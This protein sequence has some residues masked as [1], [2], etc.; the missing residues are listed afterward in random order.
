MDSIGCYARH[1]LT[2][3]LVPTNSPARKVMISYL[4]DIINVMKAF[5]QAHRLVL[6]L[7]ASSLMSILLYGIG[8]I[9][10]GAS[11]F[12]F[13]NWNLLLAWLPLLFAG[14]LVKY[15]RANPWV[16]W[17]GAVL[18]LFWLGFLPNSFYLIS[19]I[20]HLTYPDSNIL[21]YV[22]LLFL[23]SWNGLILGFLSL[24]MLHKE[25]LKRLRR[26]TAHSWVAVVILLCSFAIYL[27][28]YLR[29]STWDIVINPAGILFDVSDRLI[30]PVAYGQTFQITGLF[31]MLLGTLYFTVWEVANSRP[32]DKSY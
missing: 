7:F 11:P 20:M 2:C 23:F 29:W 6:A 12:W 31:F 18:T 21:Y 15:L 27:G 10:Y 14:L 24:Y 25:L 22:V 28:S 4:T 8:V 17:K 32:Q 5:W 3:F 16:S 19:D 9:W 1:P 13:L 26:S 30:N